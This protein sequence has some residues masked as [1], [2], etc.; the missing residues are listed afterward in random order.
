[1]VWFKVD[2]GFAFHP[3]ALAAGNAALGLWVRAGSWCGHNLTDG[4]LPES[5]LAALNGRQRDAQKLIEVGLWEKVSTPNSGHRS[6]TDQPNFD[7]T[8]AKDQPQIVQAVD[9]S[10]STVWRGRG[11]QFLDWQQWQ[12]T[13]E[14]VKAE[15]EATR[16]RVAKWREDQRNAVTPDVTNGVSTDAPTRPDPTRPVPVLPTEV[17]VSSKKPLPP[18]PKAPRGTRLP[19]DWQ[20]SLDLISWVR[21]KCPNIDGRTETENFCDWWHAKAGK[22]ATKVNWDLTYKGWMRRSN[23]QVKPNQR[24]PRVINGAPGQMRMEQ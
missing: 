12:P 5:M 3:K 14:Q 15:R 16:V 1:M 23:S 7:Q 8:L 22:D 10:D 24:G 19:D 9:V 17:P 6:A 2:D 4:F 20:P 21:L 13:K 11:F 18:S